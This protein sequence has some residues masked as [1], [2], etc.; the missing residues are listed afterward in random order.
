MPSAQTTKSK[1]FTVDAA[2]RAP[3]RIAT[4]VALLL[5]GKNDPA[6]APH[7][8]SANRVRVINTNKMKFTGKKLERET[9]IHHSGHPGGLKAIPLKKLMAE[10]SRKVLR[11]TV[12]N[13]LPKNKLRKE[14]MKHLSVDA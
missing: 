13:M 4:E 14:L 7:V 6:F 2:D 9:V 12:W 11:K 10:D 3:G 1:R 5:R 8:A